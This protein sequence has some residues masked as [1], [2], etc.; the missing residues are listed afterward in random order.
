M[1]LSFLEC[2]SIFSWNLKKVCHVFLLF[3]F[4]FSV[5]FY[6]F[7]HPG[8]LA[9]RCNIW[10]K[11][12]LEYWFVDSSSLLYF[13]KLFLCTAGTSKEILIHVHSSQW[14]MPSSMEWING[15]G[16]PNRNRWTDSKKDEVVKWT[17]IHA[18][19]SFVP[20][21]GDATSRCRIKCCVQSKPVTRLV[22]AI[23]ICFLGFNFDWLTHFLLHLENRTEGS[24]AHVY[25]AAPVFQA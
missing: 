8:L 7:W 5:S 11:P 19:P 6:Q 15:R 21:S 23:N 10:T 17:D 22:D 16:K 12:V 24:A 20:V 9:V 25:W 3:L 14:M 1:I 2:R 4:L 13:S 18:N